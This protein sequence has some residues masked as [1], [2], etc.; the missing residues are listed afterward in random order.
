MSVFSASLACVVLAAAFARSLLP[1]LK[2]GSQVVFITSAGYLAL[3]PFIA[4]ESGWQSLFGRLGLFTLI[5]LFLSVI[6]FLTLLHLKRRAVQ[7]DAPG[8]CFAAPEL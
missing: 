7:Q 5:L 6:T 1:V 2:I 3:V 8:D 4:A